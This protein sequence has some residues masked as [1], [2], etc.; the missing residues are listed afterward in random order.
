[1][2]LFYSSEKC[3]WTFQSSLNGGCENRE[4][5][6]D[7]YCYFCHHRCEEISPHLSILDMMANRKRKAKAIHEHV[8][9]KQ[10]PQRKLKNKSK[11]FVGDD[12]EDDENTVSDVCI[13][14]DVSDDDT[15]RY[16]NPQNL[17]QPSRSSVQTQSTNPKSSHITKVSIVCTN[18]ST[19]FPV[20]T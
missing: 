11:V 18:T 2:I 19:P 1:M 10:N 6:D 14:D 7:E 16:S 8:P 20:Q 13:E 9:A 17:G 4:V 12:D 15:V 5:P 3:S